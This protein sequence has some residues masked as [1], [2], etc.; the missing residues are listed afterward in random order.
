MNVNIKKI[1]ALTLALTM[2][3]G[4]AACGNTEDSS[5]PESKKEASTTTPEEDSVGESKA[6]EESKA[7]SEAESKAEEP[8]EEI[9]YLGD[10]NAEDADFSVELTNGTDKTIIAFAIKYGQEPYSDNLLPEGEEF[11]ADEVRQF[12]WSLEGSG[13]VVA[14]S[15]FTVELTFDDYEV[16]ELGF[17]LSDMVSGEI[18]LMD[19]YAFLV[20]VNKVGDSKN[21]M[22]SEESEA[23]QAREERDAATATTTTY[24]EPE[25]DP[26]PEPEPDPDP[27]VTDPPVTEPPVT[28]PPSADDGCVGDDGFTF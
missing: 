15:G 10:K 12:N 4:M 17:P 27:V 25:P 22:E 21:T 8:K 18:R 24:E 20:Y 19:E 5:E 2:T 28:E 14:P 13:N 26:E 6:E 3:V 9:K 23:E 1:L 7:E 11:K 16:F